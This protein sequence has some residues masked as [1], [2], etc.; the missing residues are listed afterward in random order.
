MNSAVPE[1]KVNVELIWKLTYREG[2][3]V[4]HTETTDDSRVMWDH[5]AEFLAN[6]VPRSEEA[7]C[8]GV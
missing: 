7:L 3:R 1:R 2:G 4:V 5:R 8:A 6:G